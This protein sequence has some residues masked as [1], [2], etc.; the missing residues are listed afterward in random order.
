MRLRNGGL[1]LAALAIGLVAA[2]SAPAQDYAITTAAEA[3]G[4]ALPLHIGGRV[5]TRGDAGDLRYRS[6]WPGVYFETAF[7]GPAAV[8]RLGEGDVRLQVTVDDR[9][10]WLTRPAAGLHRIGGLSDGDHRLRIQIVSENQAAPIDFGG[11]FG[12]AAQ[13]LDVGPRARQIEFIGD[14]HT[15]GYANTASDR[16]CSSTTVWETTDTAA[17]VAGLLA[18]RYGADYQVNA[19]SGR[20]VVRNYDGA[21]LD[22]LPQA[23][24][25]TLLDRQVWYADTGWR[26]RLIVIALGT[27]DFSTPLKPGERWSSRE[28]LTAEYERAYA[29][30]LRRLVRR[31][32]GATLMVWGLEGS[33]AAQA[34]RRVADRLRADDGLPITF[35]PV[36]GLGRNACDW[37]PDVADDGVIAAALGAAID[38]DDGLWTRPVG[39][40]PEPPGT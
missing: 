11:V 9:P 5:E 20:G 40:R 23:Y 30:F 12:D 25:F 29:G 21:A 26:P 28:Q 38:A 35:V 39:P 2:G 3:T 19:I 8:F 27:N 24:A 4:G 32:P 17:G 6:Q 10:V 16:T 7:H 13:S 36:P 31:N 1:A 18:R 22:T 15:V 34:S 33:E 14:S 37:H